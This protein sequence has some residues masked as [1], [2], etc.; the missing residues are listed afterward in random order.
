VSPTEILISIAIAV[1]IAGIIVPVLPGTILVLGAILVWAL[2]VG[3]TTAWAVFAVSALLLVVGSVV[4]YL[5]PGR[6]LKTA[7]VPNRTL[8]V[9]ALLGFIGFFVIPVI[10]MFI[11]FVLGVYVAERAR[12]GGALAWLGAN[13]H[14]ARRIPLALFALVFELSC[15]LGGLL[16]LFLWFGTEHR[17]AWRNENLLLLNPLCLALLPAWFGILRGRLRHRRFARGCVWLVAL[18]AA[19]AL[20]SKILPAFAQANLHWIVL[21]LPIHLALAFALQAASPNAKVHRG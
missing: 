17:A 13:L 14:A 5:V 11:G 12:V 4:K 16:L 7:G 8:L 1:G 21:L 10:G 20:F 19:F 9:G 15:G 3:T 6:N 18:G 2:E